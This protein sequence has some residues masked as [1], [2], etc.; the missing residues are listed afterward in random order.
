MKTIEYI[1]ETVDRA[2]V[3]FRANKELLEAKT[4][5]N[6]IKI[7]SYTKGYAMVVIY[8]HDLGSREKE[9]KFKIETKDLALLLQKRVDEAQ[10]K[11]DYLL[12]K[13]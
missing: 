6:K 12:E 1:K 3:I 4:Q 5:L 9:V 11:L 10:K 7:N 8:E 13:F 2:E